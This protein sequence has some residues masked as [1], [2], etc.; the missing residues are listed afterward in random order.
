[1]SMIDWAKAELDAAGYA[2]SDDPDDINCWMRNDVLKLIQTFADQGHSGFS[3]KHAINLFQSLA[4]WKPLSPLT[5]EPHEW[6]EVGPD[7]WQNRRASNVFKGEDGRAYWIDGIVWWAWHKDNREDINGEPYQIYFTN[8]DSRVYIDS[9]PW[10]MP[11]EPEY[12]EWVE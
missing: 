7:V 6:T 10:S 1:M 11:E 4:S 5:G 9:F 2:A 8:R 3:A 12:K